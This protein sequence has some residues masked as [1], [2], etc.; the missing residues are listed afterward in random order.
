MFLVCVVRLSLLGW[1]GLLVRVVNLRLL[2]GVVG[3]SYRLWVM[4]YGL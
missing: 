3:L 1:L 2:V 4:G